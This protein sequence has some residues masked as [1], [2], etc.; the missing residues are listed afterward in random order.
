MRKATHSFWFSHWLHKRY[1]EDPRFWYHVGSPPAPCGVDKNFNAKED[2]AEAVT[3][4]LFPEEA[5]RKAVKRNF[6]YESHGYS[7]F[8]DTPRGKFIRSLIK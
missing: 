5:Y 8:H 4:F 6:P 2:F 3:A 7:H 1:P